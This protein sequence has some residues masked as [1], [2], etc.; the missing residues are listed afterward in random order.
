MSPCARG[1]NPSRKAKIPIWNLDVYWPLYSVDADLKHPHY[2]KVNK[3]EK[4]LRDFSTM[5]YIQRHSS[6]VKAMIL[7]LTALFFLE[8]AM[9]SRVFV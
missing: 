5:S 2:G 9:L 7:K 8:S 4:W 3:H 1:R 6:F